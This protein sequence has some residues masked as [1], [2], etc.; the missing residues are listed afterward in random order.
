ML[1]AINTDEKDE[2]DEFKI[3]PFKRLYPSFVMISSP[4]F[5][6]SIRSKKMH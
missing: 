1:S 5:S 3:L 2:Q 4:A 6:K